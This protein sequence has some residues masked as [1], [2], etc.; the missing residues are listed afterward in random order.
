MIKRILTSALLFASIM[1]SAQEVV[2]YGYAPE[3][4]ADVYKVYQGQGANGHLG[5]MICL[6]PAVDPVMERLAGHQ[7][8]GVRCYLHHDYKQARQKRSMVMHTSSLDAEP[9]TQIC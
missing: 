3:E 9:T 7:I 1:L 6:D 2:R 4:I 5:G 8:K